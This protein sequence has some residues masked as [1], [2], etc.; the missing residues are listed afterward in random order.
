MFCKWRVSSSADN[1]IGPTTNIAVD[2]QRVDGNTQPQLQPLDNTVDF[3]VQEERYESDC[4][5]MY[6]ADVQLLELETGT[7]EGNQLVHEEGDDGI[8]H[9]RKRCHQGV[10]DAHEEGND[11]ISHDTETP[12]VTGGD[13]V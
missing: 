12:I 13:D 7:D 3:P 5:D 11:V 1:D 2:M 10:V 6:N 4:S 9:V 8:S